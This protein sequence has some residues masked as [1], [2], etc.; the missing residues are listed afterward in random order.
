MKLR[1]LSA[2]TGANT[3]SIKY[4][5][6]EG[7]LPAGKLRNT[8]T[9]V[10]DERHVER[11]ELILTLREDFSLPIARIRALVALIDDPEVALID[12]MEQCQL[13]ATGLPPSRT[14]DGSAG[15]AGSPP[16]GNADDDYAHD[17]V[18]AMMAEAG[19]LDVPTVA[20]DALVTELRKAASAGVAYDRTTLSLYARS[21]SEIARGDISWVRP[22]SSRDVVARNLLRGAAAQTRILVAV[23]ALAHTS[24]AI[25]SQA[26]S[27]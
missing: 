10:Y 16:D 20:R 9:A 19:W 21:L 5:I 3:A 17:E 25:A 22:A 11:I 15:K 18:S 6:R 4:W 12:V 8:T 1:E 23:N 2:R 27:Q 14:D 24:A 26:V 7:L 13:I